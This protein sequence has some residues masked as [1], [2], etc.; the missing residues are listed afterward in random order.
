MTNKELSLKIHD[1]WM[2]LSYDYAMKSEDGKF[3][4]SEVKDAFHK[5][6]EIVLEALGINLD[7]DEMV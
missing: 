3:K 2:R 7:D 5:G 4:M 6:T 1:A